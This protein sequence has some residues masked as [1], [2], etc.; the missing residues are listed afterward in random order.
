MVLG[1]WGGGRGGREEHIM[2]SPGEN[3]G[4]SPSS[5]YAFSHP[6]VTFNL[7]PWSTRNHNPCATDTFLFSLHE[8]H[9]VPSVFPFPPLCLQEH[10][11]LCRSLLTALIKY[12]F[13]DLTEQA[14]LFQTTSKAAYS[15]PLS[16]HKAQRDTSWLTG[17]S[18]PPLHA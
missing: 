14:V 17:L 11:I 9:L 6:S 12:T 5:Q 3:S 15:E 8:I 13:W 10:P 18:C 1:I 2:K 16:W 4:H 7:I